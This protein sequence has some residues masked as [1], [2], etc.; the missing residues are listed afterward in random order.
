MNDND[1]RLVNS[2]EISNYTEK[3]MTRKEQEQLKWKNSNKRLWPLLIFWIWIWLMGIILGVLAIVYA[4]RAIQDTFS[5]DDGLE[6]FIVFLQSLWVFIEAAF[7]I[8]IISFSSYKIYKIAA[9]IS[10]NNFQKHRLFVINNIT[11]DSERDYS[12]KEIKKIYKQNKKEVQAQKAK[13]KATKKQKKAQKKLEKA[14]KKAQ[15]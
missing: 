2:E 12:R 10:E 4:V 6:G 14:N 8:I 13:E 1:T 5:A 11:K 15:K 7:F 9:I 3:K